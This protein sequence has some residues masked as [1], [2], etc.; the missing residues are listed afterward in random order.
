MNVIILRGVSGAGKTTW[1]KRHY[2]RPTERAVVS[3]DHYF[4]DAHGVYRFDPARLADAHGQC[5]LEFLACIRNIDRTIIVDNTNTTI[6]EMAPYIAI[7][8]AYKYAVQIVT[9]DVSPDVA[10]RRNVHGVEPATVDRQLRQ[11]NESFA[12]MPRRWL[13]YVAV[14]KEAA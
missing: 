2:P 12:R 3:A 10:A 11:L 8:E 4:T 5:L 1:V 14:A 13:P 7:A 9:L 6:E